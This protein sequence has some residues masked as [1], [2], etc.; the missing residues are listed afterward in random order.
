[1]KAYLTCLAGL[2]ISIIVALSF[3]SSGISLLEVSQHLLLNMNGGAIAS[4][5]ELSSIIMFEIRLP[6]ILVAG[7]T[8]ASLAAAG[9]VSQGLFRNTL[10]SPSILGTTSGGSLVAA[11]MFFYGSAFDHW[12][13]LPIGAFLGAAT[14]TYILFLISKRF[15]GLQIQSLLLAGFALNALLGACTSFVI[16]LMLEDQQKAASVMHWMLGGFAARGMEHFYMVLPTFLIGI[17]LATNITH[18]LDILALGEEK[19][20]TLNVN[21][22]VLWHISIVCIALLVGGSVAVAGAI[23]FVGLVVPH[24]TRLVFGPK[25]RN[26]LWLSAINGASLILLMD[27][28]ARTLMAPKEIEVGVLISLFGAPFF[29]WLLLSYK[30]GVRN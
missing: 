11:S 3:G 6:R 5:T 27:L 19:A 26:L 14:A 23:P 1:M 9:V 30:E 20:Q 21:M 15:F 25:H 16:S 4:Q 10:A 12:Y 17:F 7:I 13:T 28:L 29:I 8:G 18:K 2:L 22:K 24:M